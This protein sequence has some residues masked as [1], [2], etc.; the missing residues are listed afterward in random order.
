MKRLMLL[1]VLSSAGCTNSYD[2]IT[3]YESVRA[4]S[5]ECSIRSNGEF[6]VEPDQFDPPVTEVWGVHLRSDATLLYLGEEVWVMDAQPDGADPRADAH[7]T[8]RSSTQT[9]GS[10]GCTTTRVE[11]ITFVADG[12]ALTG[13]VTNRTVLEGAAACGDTPV[14]ERT[15]DVVNGTGSGP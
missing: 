6:C 9:D 1:A 15:I 14:G 3:F 5:E 10:S 8:S 7:T 13:T 11:S 12:T 2:G 4:R